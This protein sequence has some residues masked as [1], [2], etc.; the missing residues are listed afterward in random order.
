M[1]EKL[2]HELQPAKFSKG[3]TPDG[4]EG[5]GGIDHKE[6][7]EHRRFINELCPG[8]SDMQGFKEFMDDFYQVSVSII[9]IFSVANKGS[10]AWIFSFQKTENVKPSWTQNNYTTQL[11]ILANTQIGLL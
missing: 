10:Q 1:A 7:Y 8:P 4:A 6:C 2:N 11:N 9:S 3:Y 5:Y